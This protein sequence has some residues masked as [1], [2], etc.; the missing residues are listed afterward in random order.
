MTLA[1][2]KL[3]ERG[4]VFAY[5]DRLYHARVATLDDMEDD[6]NAA[7]EGIQGPAQAEL[8]AA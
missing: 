1:I 8:R 6:F 7:Q 5:K 2:R 4:Q 3:K